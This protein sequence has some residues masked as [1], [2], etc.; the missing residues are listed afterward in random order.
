MEDAG[1][2]ARFFVRLRRLTFYAP[3]P[4]DNNSLVFRPHDGRSPLPVSHP[5]KGDSSETAGVPC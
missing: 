5:H 1:A 4:G 2:T 3:N